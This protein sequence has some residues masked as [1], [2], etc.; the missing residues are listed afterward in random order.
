VTPVRVSH[1]YALHVVLEDGTSV[2]QVPVEVDW[3]P[4]GECARFDTVRRGHPPEEAFRLE[5]SVEPV[6]HPSRGEPYLGGFGVRANGEA[7]LAQFSTR[8]FAELAR[9]ATTQLV[10]QGALEEG[11]R[12]R[13]LPVAFPRASQPEHD[14]TA[15][16]LAARATSPRV[17]VRE[18][19]LADYRARAANGDA[20]DSTDA[21]LFVPAQ[22]L[23]E[24]ADLTRASPRCETGGILVG[25]LHRDR[26]AG[27]VFLEVTAQIPARHTEADVAKL[28]FTADTWTDVRSALELRRREE[29]M[30]GWWHSH[31]VR[32]WCRE[33]PE[34]KQ[35]VCPLASGFLSEHD[36]A[37][38]RT[39]F[40]RAYS[41]ALVVNDVA[42]DAPTFSLFG[43][44]SGLIESR[45]FHVLEPD[46]PAPERAGVANAAATEE[47]GHVR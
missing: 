27:D 34:E 16:R 32:E 46:R 36:R 44:R 7:D 24:A 43:W 12:V 11:A 29:I 30:L 37:L 20:P 6:W 8:Y 15:L 33:C 31:P 4:A 38:H 47:T 9:A 39:V 41:V 19:S 5:C 25:H 21:P 10:R 2:A 1:A 40:P 28:T 17:P 45:G 13:C 14:G 3:E 18:R 26:D 23:E 22:V 35:R 42:P